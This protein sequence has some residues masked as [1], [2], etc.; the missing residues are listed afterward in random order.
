[1]EKSFIRIFIAFSQEIWTE[2]NMIINKLCGGVEM[3]C[4]CVYT[5]DDAP[6]KD[7]HCVLDL[8]HNGKVGAYEWNHLQI[9]DQFLISSVCYEK[10]QLSIQNPNLITRSYHASIQV[11]QGQFLLYDSS[12][13][14]HLMAKPNSQESKPFKQIKQRKIKVI[15]LDMHAYK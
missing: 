2:E 14:S 5:P 13:S 1:M 8:D 3:V 4:I 7:T 11:I 12:I 6:F 10:K 9:V 15:Q